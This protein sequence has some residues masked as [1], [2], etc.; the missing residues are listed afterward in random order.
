M[1]AVF[2]SFIS[3]LSWQQVSLLLDTVQYFEEAPKLLSL[4]QEE[5]ASVAV[6]ITAETLTAMLNHLDEQD[7]FTRKSF[8]LSWEEGEQDGHGT[9]V[10]QLPTGDT[11]RQAADL[12]LF[13][14]V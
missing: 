14:A 8:A 12:S 3:P 2:E 7:A 10:V 13:S 5:G 1:A 4:P 9:L 11:V 6:P